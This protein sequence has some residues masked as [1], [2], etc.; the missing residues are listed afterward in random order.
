MAARWRRT[1]AS[2]AAAARCRSM[3][4]PRST[5]AARRPAATPTP[6]RTT[7]QNF[8]PVGVGTSTAAFSITYVGTVSGALA[9]QTVHIANN[10]G[11]VGEQT[12]S[13]TGAAWNYAQASAHTPEPVL[14]ANRHVG[15]AASQ[16]LT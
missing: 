6:P 13:L 3:P 10:F 8:G 9:G 15:V 5:S 2:T 4:A 11:N 7:A 12:I 14:F 1:P 16:A